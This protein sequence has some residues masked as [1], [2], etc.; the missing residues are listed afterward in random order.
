M[1]SRDPVSAAAAPAWARPDAAPALAAQVVDLGWLAA[2]AAAWDRL[3]AQAADQNPFFSRPLI[4]AHASS[5]IAGPGLR[6]IVVHRGED[7]RALVPVAVRGSRIGLRRSHAVWTSRFLV[8]NA[9]PL[10]A[11]EEIDAALEAL[12]DRAAAVQGAS[13]WRWPHLALD[14]RTG[15]ALQEALRRRGWPS[16]ILAS[17]ER[18][19]LDPR[20]DYDVFAR[21]HLAPG[22]R[23]RLKRQRHR[24]AQQGVLAH[25]TFS[26]G[27]GLAAA[28]ES[29][30]ALERDGWKGA[31]GTALASRPDTAALARAAFRPEGG[32]VS[33]RA[34]VLSLSGAPLAISLALVC[35]GTAYLLKTAY[36]ERFRS[37]APGLILEDEIIRAVHATR[38]AKRLDSASDAGGV[39]ESFYPDRERMG[40]LVFSTDPGLAPATLAGLVARER[41]I[42]E[43]RRGLKRVYWRA[44][45]LRAAWFGRPARP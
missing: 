21:A 20:R 43:L 38:F 45:D 44:V 22:R 2:R 37:F 17:V 7:L 14:G 24:L 19:V 31:R 23:K 42:E 39:L 15:R 8:V 13:L 36:D 32:P 5:A 1:F 3:S 26:E 9:T 25:K 40:E 6:F 18:P 27:E 34:D 41:R 33:V 30:L 11:A 35:G 10:A 29:F 28:V 4:E 12:L 16:E